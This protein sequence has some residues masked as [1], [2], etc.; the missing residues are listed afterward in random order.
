LSPTVDR[1]F[2]DVLVMAP[3]P[4]LRRARLALLVHLRHAIV[5]SVGDI[6]ELAADDR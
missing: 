2:A 4:A 3:D 1:F 5:S 6:S